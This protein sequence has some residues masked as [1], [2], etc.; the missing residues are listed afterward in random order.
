MKKM[1]ANDLMV[2]CDHGSGL[3]FT[4]GP[5]IHA[6]AK[7]DIPDDVWVWPFTRVDGKMWTNS[8]DWLSGKT[9]DEMDE[10]HPRG[11]DRTRS[12][13]G[14]EFVMP[15][16]SLYPMHTRDTR[17]LLDATKKVQA[18]DLKL[19]RRYNFACGRCQ[20]DPPLNAE[21]VDAQFDWLIE[22]EIIGVSLRMLE[23]MVEH[24]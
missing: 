11:K 10:A 14:V 5:L 24:G 2:F 22:D 20:Y 13:G 8:A 19:I 17:K 12:R 23:G 4:L 18:G 1:P 15:D 6:G 16:G 7:V 9:F 3:D 21:K